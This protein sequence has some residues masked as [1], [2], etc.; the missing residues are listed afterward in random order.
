RRGW[1]TDTDL[2]WALDT[3]AKQ[4]RARL[5][6]ILVERGLVSRT[7]LDAEMRRLVEEIVFSTFA[8]GTGGYRLQASA[9]VLDPCW[10]LTLPRCPVASPSGGV[11]RGGDRRPARERR[12]RRASRRRP[13]P[14]D[15]RHRPDVPLPVPAARAAGGVSAVADRRHPGRRLAAEDRRHIARRD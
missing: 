13:P 5:G 15:A 14:P 8:W 1:I 10:R 3:V 7:V 12:V 4:G 11:H 9:V 2:N 6:K